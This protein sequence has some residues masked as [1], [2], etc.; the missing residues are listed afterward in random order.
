MKASTLHRVVLPLAVFGVLV[1]AQGNIAPAPEIGWTLVYTTLAE[2]TA[3]VE[4]QG[5]RVEEIGTA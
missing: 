1:D 4:R 3:A 5:G 2:L